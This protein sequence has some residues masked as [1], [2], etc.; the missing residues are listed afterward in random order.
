MKSH[1]VWS[2]LPLGQNRT[3]EN[4]NK[5]TTGQLKLPCKHLRSAGVFSVACGLSLLCCVRVCHVPGEDL[6]WSTTY[7]SVRQIRRHLRPR[8][9]Q[10]GPSDD[11]ARLFHQICKGEIV[12]GKQPLLQMDDKLFYFDNVSF[13]APGAPFASTAITLLS[14]MIVLSL[15][16]VDRNGTCQ[17]SIKLTPRPA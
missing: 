2:F 17:S 1:L 5:R 6:D 15:F 7:C 11:Q 12:G 8:K 10:P 16:Y 14:R 13:V 4:K 9:D 3:K